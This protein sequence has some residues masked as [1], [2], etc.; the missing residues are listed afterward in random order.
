MNLRD[1]KKDL[2]FYI[3]A[4]IDDCTLFLNIHP[5]RE[6]EAITGLI[7]EAA[8][9]YNDLRDRVAKPEGS[10]R[11]YYDGLRKEMLDKLDGLY[12]RLAEA[13]KKGLEKGKKQ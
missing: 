4:F 8:D 13:A 12:D 7:D 10:K 1:I 6:A 3:G 11:A 5:D 2:G 9:L